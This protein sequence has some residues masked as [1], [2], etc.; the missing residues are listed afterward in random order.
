MEAVSSAVLPPS[1]GEQQFDGDGFDAFQK[2]SLL[3][4]GVPFFGQSV[5][6]AVSSATG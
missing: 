2:L 4:V 3:N 5:T 6:C 1:T